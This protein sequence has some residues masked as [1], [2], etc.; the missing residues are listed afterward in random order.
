MDYCSA[1]VVA[2]TELHSGE[3]GFGCCVS[4]S[5]SVCLWVCVSYAFDSSTK[6]V[7]IFVVYYSLL[8]PNRCSLV[9][10][11]YYIYY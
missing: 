3:G 6:W 2:H 5:W 11:V 7:E 8:P 1:I 9:P 4:L 10:L